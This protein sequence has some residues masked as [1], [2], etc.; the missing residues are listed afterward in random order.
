MNNM[1]NIMPI[2]KSKNFSK[3]ALK[4]LQEAVRKVV[5][6]RKRT[7]V[8]LSIW[9]DGKVLTIPADKIDMKKLGL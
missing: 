9:K 7:G 4:A 3:Q 2:T 5:I 8:D 6:E 1:E